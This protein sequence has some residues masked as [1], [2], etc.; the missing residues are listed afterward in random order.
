MPLVVAVLMEH[1]SDWQ[2]QNRYM[3]IDGFAEPA[4]KTVDQ[5]VADWTQGG[6]T[7][8]RLSYTRKLH[9]IDGR[10]PLANKP[11]REEGIVGRIV[12]AAAS[13]AKVIV[14]GDA[15][16]QHAYDEPEFVD[17]SARRRTCRPWLRA[18]GRQNCDSRSHA[19]TTPSRHTRWRLQEG[20]LL[21]ASGRRQTSRNCRI[22]FRAAREIS[23]FQR[24]AA[25][26]TGS[27]LRQGVDVF[28]ARAEVT[29][30]RAL[31]LGFST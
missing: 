16:R 17:D 6:L 14:R 23:F 31:E 22:R 9:H 26:Y 28:F 3:Q 13:K 7:N 27:R 21:R 4:D 29:I 8:D 18:E 1:N 2:T 30:E 19:A 24:D 11:L 10:D 5:A 12:M 15:Q 25:I 20:V